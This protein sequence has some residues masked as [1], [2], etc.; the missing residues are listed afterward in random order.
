MASQD[1]YG[2]AY[3]DQPTDD[4][5]GW[6]NQQG[7]PP[8]PPPDTHI[9]W[10][11]TPGWQDPFNPPSPD[12]EQ[13]AEWNAANPSYKDLRPE[14]FKT[15]PPATDTKTAPAPPKGGSITDLTAPYTGTFTP[16]VTRFP[17][18]TGTGVPDTPRF[19]AP[20][21]NKP[22][23]FSYEDYVAP[24]LAEA[25][26]DPGYLFASNEG[27]RAL[28]QGAAARGLL[29]S[30]GTLKDILAWGGNYGQQRY[31]D[32]DARKRNTYSMNR[33]NAVGNYNTNYQTQYQDPYAIAY[34]SA[35]DMFAPEMTGYSTN[36]AA[37]QRANELDYSNA[38]DLS[39]FDFRKFVDQRDSTFNK[40]FAV[41]TA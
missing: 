39:Q 27:R 41:A 11:T 26:A 33:A 3:G 24:T 17:G 20:G 25:E 31:S 13:W 6:S 9:R 32:V 28:E 16:P 5:G 1:P 22:P 40:R 35:S 23:A 34:R 12:D 37:N 10:Q 29:N 7:P 30:G 14:L 38:W 19:N 21:Y 18:A 8:P 15:T 36:A 4:T 2:D